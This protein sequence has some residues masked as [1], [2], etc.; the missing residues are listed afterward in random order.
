MNEYL[1]DRNAS[2]ADG[3]QLS[4]T[5][6]LTKTSPG[7][8]KAVPAVSIKRGNVILL[9]AASEV[10]SPAENVCVP[11]SPKA[12]EN[13]PCRERIGEMNFPSF[14]HSHGAICDLERPRRRQTPAA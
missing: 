8:S 5:N 7:E 1:S 9:L 11:E 12:L 13:A 3:W 2:G 6:R 4:L 10:V 14:T